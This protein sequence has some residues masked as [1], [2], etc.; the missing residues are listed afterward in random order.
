MFKLRD[1][2]VLAALQAPVHGSIGVYEGGYIATL[3]GAQVWVNLTC[4]PISGLHGG[5]DGGIAFIDDVSERKRIESVLQESEQKLRAIA[6]NVNTVMFLKDLQGRYL[7]V[8]RQYEKLFHVSNE[9]IQG[10][11][12]HDI[13]PAELAQAFVANDHIVIQTQRSVE[14]EEQALHD[15]GLHTYIAVKL[16]IRN[17]AGEIYAVCGIAT[18]ITER[19]L[20]EA[21]LRIAASAFESQEGM[22]ITDAQTKI[23]R[24]N[25]AFTQSTGYAA[26]E[27]VGHTPRMLQSGRHDADFY[28]SMWDSIQRTGGWQGEIW[29]RRKDGEIYPKWLTISSVKGEDGVVTNYIGT[30]HDITERKRAEEKIAELAFFD[31]LTR[32]PNRTLLMD[33][34]KQTMTASNRAGTFGALLFIDLDQFKTLNDTLGHGQGD[35]LLQQ[36]ANRLNACVRGGDT[37]ARLGGDEFVVVLENL[38][39]NSD[40]A[41]TQ[42]KALGEKIHSS[43]GQIYQ[44]GTVEHRITASI[45]A[46]LFLGQETAVDELLKQADL[47][48]Y[49]A[50]ETGR[51]ALRFFDPAMQS[52][53]L[54]RASLEKNLRRAL[55]EQQFVLHYQPQVEGENMQVIGAEA[56]IRWAHPQRGLMP[57]TYFIPLAEETGLILPIGHWVLETACRQLARWAKQP[58]L[59]HLSLAV[60]ISANQLHEDDFVCQVES[61]LA[62]TGADPKR[63]KLELTES[64][65]V[66]EVE[67]AIKKMAALKAMGVGFSLDDF[68]TGYSSLSYLKRLPLDQLKIDRSFVEHILIDSNDAAIAKM[69]IALAESLS[70]SVVAEGVELESQRV[71]LAKLGC[72]SYQGYLFSRPLALKEFEDFAARN[73]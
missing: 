65:L 37:V 28:R 48:M 26:E 21:D 56:L 49:K 40:D 10:K 55:H 24:V 38:S 27:V 2:R 30:H 64:L 47:A 4:T 20:A 54:E 42:T 29:D 62:S 11:T 1:Q 39:E 51:N 32:L 50:K 6:D 67:E 14:V 8:N 61:V 9:E 13:F 22:M 3:S 15:D 12:D 44:L 66:T 34:L 5:N 41:A 69:V 59:A 68:G 36:V 31:P 18:D 7:Y 72:N 63:L 46:T 73:K 70:L 25:L 33:R 16:P 45:G 17:S 19:K 53:V 58:A 60:N 23:L 71:F 52:I 35:L 43:L 57:P